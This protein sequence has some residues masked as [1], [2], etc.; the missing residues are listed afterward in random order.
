[1]IRLVASGLGL[2]QHLNHVEPPPSTRSRPFDLVALAVAKQGS[3]YRRENRNL[4]RKS[5]RLNSSHGYI[6]YAV[7]CLKNNNKHN[8]TNEQL[9]TEIAIMT[10]CRIAAEI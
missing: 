2:V 9:E 3:S 8:Y 7:F 10:G 1:M 5:T 6:S 4:D